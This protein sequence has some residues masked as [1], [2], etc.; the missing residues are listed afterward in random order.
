[1]A[2]IIDFKKKLATE[3]ELSEYMARFQ[4]C[5]DR[6]NENDGVCDCDL[7]QTKEEFA[8][9][10]IQIGEGLFVDYTEQTNENLY[11]GDLFEVFITATLKLKSY[12]AQPSEN[13]PTDPPKA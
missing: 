5:V 3:K 10:L 7:C 1:M 6:A 11:Y 9:R 13:P 8:D 12:C 2:D 4:K